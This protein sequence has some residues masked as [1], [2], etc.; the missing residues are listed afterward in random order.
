[1][2]QN[3]NRSFYLAPDILPAG[4]NCE[5]NYFIQWAGSH[6]VV[7]KTG[8]GRDKGFENLDDISGTSYIDEP[9]F[10]NRATDG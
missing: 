8:S 10:P 5:R 1:M 7:R 2:R 9:R 4:E 3:S 6:E